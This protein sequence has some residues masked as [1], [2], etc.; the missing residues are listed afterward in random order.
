MGQV[1]AIRY[2]RSAELHIA[3]AVSGDGPIDIVMV[4]GWVSHVEAQWEEDHF[5][6][7]VERLGSFARVIRFDKRN[8][9][10]SDRLGDV[11]PELEE[12]MDDVRAVMDAA[13]SQQAAVIGVS[14]GA[15]MSILFAA[16]F[17]DRVSALVL[18]GATARVAAA[19][20]YRFGMSEAGMERFL[21]AVERG[22]GRGVTLPLAYPGGAG[23]PAVQE[24][25][26]RYERMA[27]SPGAAV[28]G[29]EMAGRVDTRD[30]LP[31]VR[32]PTLV[33]HRAGDRLVSVEHGRYLAEHIPGARYVEM[34]GDDHMPWLGDDGT[35][36]E[37]IEEFLTGTRRYHEPDRVLATVLF[38]DIVGS[39]EEAAKLGD[40]RWHELLD[41]HDRRVRRELDRFNGREVKTTGDGF[42]ATFDGPAR[43][44]RC[45]AA[46]RDSIGG[47]GLQIR[48]GLHTGEVELRNGDVGGV[49]VH[50]GAR[51]AATAE[52]GEVVVSS[53][54]KDLVA[55]AN[56]EFADRGEHELKGV[57]GRWHLYAVVGCS[58]SG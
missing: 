14:E 20:D 40:R 12:R 41:D 9:G 3:Y 22:W 18:A 30:L 44:I 53:T 13:G 26:A 37:E 1:P 39:T 21:N 25:W 16:T 11:F 58:P 29:L 51:V 48:A 43:T 15:A 54:V 33:L 57:P 23:D 35:A 27:A 17:P 19:P 46:I 36:A 56:I 8:T 50:I 45:A 47:I 34:D 6:R 32:V 24:W 52:P 4:P 42:L 7:F 5:R 2:A 38:T 31:V 28:A 10:L 55:G 49:A